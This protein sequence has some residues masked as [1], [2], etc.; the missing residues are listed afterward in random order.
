MTNMLA[1][2]SIEGLRA[3]LPESADI[4]QEWQFLTIRCQPE[5][6]PEV[7]GI[8]KEQ[9]S[10]NYLANLTAVDYPDG[11]EMVYHLFSLP[12][13]NK[14]CVKSRLDQAQPEIASLVRLFPTADWQEREVFDLMGIRFSGHPNLIRVLLPDDFVGHP[15]RKDFKKEA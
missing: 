1:T 3:L 9:A 11:L 13:R 10:C 4:Q 14:I 15:L 8:L 5:H 6:V 7:L 12:G 2:L